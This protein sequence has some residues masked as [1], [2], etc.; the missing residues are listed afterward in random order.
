MD[1]WR[2]AGGVQQPRTHVLLA[3]AS[4]AGFLRMAQSAYPTPEEAADGLLAR[5]AHDGFSIARLV[6]CEAC[7]ASGRDARLPAQ[8]CSVCHGSTRQVI[9]WQEEEQLTG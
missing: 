3:R 6:P 2:V 8:P 4:I 1:P 5:L 7:G 9:A